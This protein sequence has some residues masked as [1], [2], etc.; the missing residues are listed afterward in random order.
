MRLS[1]DGP[2]RPNILMDENDV[3]CFYEGIPSGPAFRNDSLAIAVN[4]A[5]TASLSAPGA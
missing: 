1:L 5:I 3:Y 2:L 4:V